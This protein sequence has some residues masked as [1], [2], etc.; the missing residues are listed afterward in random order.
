MNGNAVSVVCK[1]QTMVALSTVEAE[2]VAMSE[3]VRDMKYVYQFSVPLLTHLSTIRMP[4]RAVGDSTGTLYNAQNTVNNQ[5]T[6]HIDVKIHFIRD[7]VMKKNREPLSP[8]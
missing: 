8:L 2:Y 6:K 3:M 1:K 5:R 7:E 4:L